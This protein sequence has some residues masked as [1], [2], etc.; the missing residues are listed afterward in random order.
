VPVVEFWPEFAANGK[1]GI[2]VGE[3]MSHQAGLPGALEPI[4]LDDLYAHEGVAAKLAAQEPLFAPGAWGYHALTFGTLADELV[5]RTDGRTI[6][7]FFT[8]EVRIPLGIEVYTGLPEDRDHLVAETIPLSLDNPARGFDPPD[9]RA[10][11]AAIMNPALDFEWPNER[12]WREH[13]LP[14]AGAMGNARGLAMLYGI[15]AAGGTVDGRTLISSAALREATVE[16]IA[17]VDRCLGGVGRYGAGF[18]LNH[19]WFGSDM[20]SF[21]HPG[22]GGTSAF[23]DSRRHLG[24]AYTTNHMV[25]PDWQSIDPRLSTLLSALYVSDV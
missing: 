17:G 1:A 14:G 22:M 24:I 13:G 11:E 3:L 12:H 9:M 19:G 4:T 16:R 8:E 23:A 5:R 2:T 21:G 25:N 20:D 18:R 15:L 7:R 10:L 6:N